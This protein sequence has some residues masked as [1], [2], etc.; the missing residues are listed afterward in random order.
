M[1]TKFL[2]IALVVIAASLT[3]SCSKDDDPAPIVDTRLVLPATLENNTLI[4]IP[5][6][7]T[8]LGDCGTGVTPGNAQSTI[9]IIGTGIIT[10]PS[11]VTIELDIEHYYGGDLVIELIAPSGES[12]GL[13]KRLGATSDSTCG[14]SSNF[15]TGN[16]LS[17]N[18]TFTTTLTANE[19]VTGNYAP[20]QGNSNYPT[21]V[22]M[23]SLATFLTG[24][25]ITGIWKL[26]MYDYGVGDTGKLNSWK[27]KFETGA[28]Q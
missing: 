1:K 9:E 18:S 28:L 25:N 26:K 8:G 7:S 12:C 19:I 15:I 20:T 3:L 11:K 6:A 22:P 21:T 2:K 10:D 13:I 27:L 5:D 24:K 4:N 14:N 16:K 23:I 17:F